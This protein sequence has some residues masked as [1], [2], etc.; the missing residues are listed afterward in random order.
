MRPALLSAFAGVVVFALTGCVIDLDS[1]TGPEQH[2]TQSVD[3]DKAEMVRVEIK[4]G[5][6]ELEVD[7]GASKLM[8]ADFTYNVP[9]WK[10]AVKYT[11]SGFRGT[12]RIEQPGNSHG[13]SHVKYDWNV[14]LNDKVPMDIS[15]EF[16]AGKARMNLGS[17]D[18]RSVH[19]E[20]G[21]GEVQLDLRGKPTR[22]YSVDVQ[23][24]VGKATIYLPA[25]VGI[26]AK[27]AGGIGHIRVDGLEKRG[28]R[29]I[30]PAHENSPVTIHLNVEGG[31]GEINLI[32]E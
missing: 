10:P 13:G 31:V 6:G 4:L 7:G 12:L 15:A 23:G 18:L 20:M 29:Y 16:G 19:V 26:S 27:A 21:V 32:A 3:L 9:S 17:L 11:S 28:D 25:D 2:E 14:R 8:D 24:G 22:D 5:A 30:N 1:R